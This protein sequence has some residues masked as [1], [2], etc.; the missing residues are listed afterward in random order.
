VLGH[1]VKN[2]PTPKFTG[3]ENL[4]GPKIYLRASLVM[5]I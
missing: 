4:P 1:D 3:S 2:Y 5:P